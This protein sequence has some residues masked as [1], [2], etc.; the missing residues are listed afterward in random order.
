MSPA[1][2]G[3]AGRGS[4]PAG[5]PASIAWELP[6]PAP[7]KLNLFLHV[8]GRR[9]DGY[10]LLQTAFR[11]IDLADS[12]VFRPRDDGRIVLEGSLPDV[13]D[14]SNLVVRAARAVGKHLPRPAGAT[15]ALRKTI[16]I[17]G[18]LGGGSSDAATTL[19]ALNRLWRVGLSVDQLADLGLSLGADVPVFVRGENAFGEG[20]GE[21]LTPIRLGPAWYVVLVPQ[22]SIPTGEIFGD[23]ALTRDTRPI[24]IP[25]FFAGQQ[26]SNDLEAVVRR[27]YPEVAAHLDWLSRFMRARM[28]GSGACVF[29]E[30]S[31]ENEA[32]SV[33]A[34][35]PAPMKGF[36]ARGLDRHPLSSAD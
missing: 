26:T 18:G 28:T 29:A 14:E 12:L 33:L 4:V 13:E 32:R 3:P 1:D 11:F 30:A 34:R 35:L 23:P 36:V 27:R 22:V 25:A 19:I 7:A 16:P 31:D 9:P 6:L 8:T 10:H 21:R 15:I 17:G 24:T 5:P 2:P 20:V